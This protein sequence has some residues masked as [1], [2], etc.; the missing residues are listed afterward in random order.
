VCVWGGVFALEVEERVPVLEHEAEHE[1]LARRSISTDTACAA[2]ACAG[3]MHLTWLR[4]IGAPAASRKTSKKRSQRALR[5]KVWIAAMKC[6][7]KCSGT[8]GRRVRLVRGE[9]RDV[10]S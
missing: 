1:V 8:C 2:D 9:G 5:P 6:R 7:R 10:S 4:R 3:E